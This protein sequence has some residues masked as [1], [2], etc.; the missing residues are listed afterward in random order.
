MYYVKI[1]VKMFL[2]IE[3]WQQFVLKYN[4]R[5]IQLL[6]NPKNYGNDI[7]LFERL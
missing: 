5:K 3:F 6:N 2:E 7:E 4:N 1:R